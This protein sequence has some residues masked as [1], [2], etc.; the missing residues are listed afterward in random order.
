MKIGFLITARLKSSRLPYKLLLDLNGKTMIERVIDRAKEVI[1][2]D[3]IVLCTS[4]NTQDNPLKAIS[5]KNGIHCFRG[6]EADVLQRLCD[7][8]DFHGFDHVV[9]ITGEN[10][11][12]SIEMAH[13]VK[14]NIEEAKPDFTYIN[15]LPIGCAVYGLNIKAL[16]VVCEIKQ[17]VDTEI[18]GYLINRPEI[19]NVSCIEAPK[20]M[21]IGDVRITSD[22]P[23]DFELLSQLYYA[24]GNHNIPNYM[25]L[26]ELLKERPDLLNINA[27]RKQADVDEQMKE[28]INS[29]FNKKGTAIKEMLNE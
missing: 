1:S 2:T 16:R 8:A 21:R 28:R 15:G 10:P 12:F 20:E 5:Q 4:I 19:F 23:E 22:Y 17:E 7:A 29:F 9:N 14:R 18:W 25:S 13:Q 6:S 3:R 26:V 27:N 24:L 11:F